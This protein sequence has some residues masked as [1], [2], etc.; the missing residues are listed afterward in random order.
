M[1]TGAGWLFA[2]FYAP[3]RCDLR[4]RRAVVMAALCAYLLTMLGMPVYPVTVPAV[5]SGGEPFPCQHHR[6]GCSSLEQCRDRC[7]CH[8]PSQRLAWARQ[9]GVEEQW[10]AALADQLAEEAAQAQV[11]RD[12]ATVLPSCC[13]TTALPSCCQAAAPVEEP[14]C[15][16]S[17]D[18]AEPATV[19]TEEPVRVQYVSV[20][21]ARKCQG[22]LSLWMT[23]SVAAPVA[24]P[25]P[26]IERPEPTGVVTPL[27][28]LSEGDRRAP[29]APPPRAA[30]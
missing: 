30:A 6:C 26:L 19:A 12:Q 24:P 14:S 28:V 3:H 27:F 2:T 25:H 10:R 18:T 5:A 23:L 11:L 9:Q 29:D 13:Q 1:F 15:C 20:L 22:L 21:Q 16:Q 7:C 17:L 4:G 8:S